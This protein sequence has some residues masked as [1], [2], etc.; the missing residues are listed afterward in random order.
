MD[1]QRLRQLAGIT[2]ADYHYHGTEVTPDNFDD[3][4]KMMVAKIESEL[5][6][7]GH[8]ELKQQMLNA[9]S[10]QQLAKIMVTAIRKNR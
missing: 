5:G 10:P 7:E 4:K 3:M 8:E 6:K 2:E 9:K 1:K